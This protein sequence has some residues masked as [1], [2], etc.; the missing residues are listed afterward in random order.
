[1]KKAFHISSDVFEC[2]QAYSCFCLLWTFVNIFLSFEY[3]VGRFW[4]YIVC[5]IF[6]PNFYW[7]I[8]GD[9][10]FR[11]LSENIVQVLLKLRKRNVENKEVNSFLKKHSLI[12]FTTWK[13]S[14]T[15]GLY[16]EWKFQMSNVSSIPNEKKKSRLKAGRK[17]LISR[18]S[19]FL[20]ANSNIF[21]E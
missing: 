9:L 2:Y 21:F 16:S 7:H 12:I 3:N 8:T 11:F 15:I 20:Q 5:V 1:M 13:F 18:I 6:D 14:F 4:K 17:I 10:R 19:Q